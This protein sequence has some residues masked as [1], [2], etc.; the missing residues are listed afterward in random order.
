M[1]DIAEA[2]VD[3]FVEAMVI[4]AAVAA[5]A[6]VAVV[7]IAAASV[8]QGLSCG[9][10]LLCVEAPGA[11]GG[12]PLGRHFGKSRF[13]SAFS[14][15]RLV[16]ATARS[17]LAAGCPFCGHREEFAAL[18]AAWMRCDVCSRVLAFQDIPDDEARWR[19][20]PARS[21]LVFLNVSRMSLSVCTSCKVS[22]DVHVCIFLFLEKYFFRNRF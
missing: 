10:W 21:L 20:L 8:W 17:C 12:P 1:S 5:V 9:C 16:I 22:D 13:K 18:N 15:I 11:G 3:V 6:A 14:K 4:A 7:V 19:N 2:L